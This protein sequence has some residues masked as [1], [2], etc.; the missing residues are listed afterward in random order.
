MLFDQP[1]VLA[2]NAAGSLLPTP[3]H[4][5][6]WATT[7]FD[8]WHSLVRS[9]ADA[10]TSPT[11][12]QLAIATVLNFSESP[13]SMYSSLASYPDPFL[14]LAR[15]APVSSL[16][17]TAASSWLFA[18]K[19]T[20]DSWTAS[21]NYLRSWASSP[22]AAIATWWSGKILRTYFA[23][24]SLPP[25]TRPLP[26]GLEE[27]WCLYLAALVIWAY[28][29]PNLSPSPMS[30][31]SS[32]SPSGKDRMPAISRSKT[33]PRPSLGPV[34]L[35]KPDPNTLQLPSRSYSF[36][37]SSS[38]STSMSTSPIPRSISPVHVAAVPSRRGSP[39]LVAA[40]SAAAPYTAMQA[41][42]SRLDTDSW[43]EVVNVRATG[44]VEGVIV[45]VRG[46]LAR[47]G[48]ATGEKGALIG[49]AGRVLERLVEG[50]GMAW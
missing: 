27:D 26:T 30:A 34:Q 8:Q 12:F 10:G 18:R 22:D 35:P 6:A 42:L 7:D 50:R 38:G 29:Y 13:S 33:H 41:F 28:T 4:A 46:A 47:G 3:C 5:S 44:G 16:I 37:R 32:R 1:A 19:V 23:K 20:L 49:E 39:F 11:R 9:P 15:Y 43:Q 17:I 2:A 31:G 36:G 21:K 25:N 40:S 48:G 24:Q 14:Q 45:G